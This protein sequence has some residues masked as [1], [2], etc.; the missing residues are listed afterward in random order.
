M[1]NVLMTY[2]IKETSKSIHTDLKNELKENG[3]SERIQADDQTWYD[4]PNTTLRKPGITS[5]TGSMEFVAACMTVGAKWEKYICAE[6]TA[7]TFNNQKV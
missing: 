3:W 4:L 5:Q 2:D 1:A 6:Y 7:A